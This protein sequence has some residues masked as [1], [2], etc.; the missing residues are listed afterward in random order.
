MK[1]KPALASDFDEAFYYIKNLWA[2]FL[3]I[4]ESSIMPLHFFSFAIL[5]TSLNI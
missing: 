3:G 4:P 2:S 5:L 1:F